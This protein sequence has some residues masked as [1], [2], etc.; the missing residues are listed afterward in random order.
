MLPY[1]IPTV[2]RSSSLC[3]SHYMM[4]SMFCNEFLYGDH[5]K[6]VDSGMQARR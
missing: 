2:E 1:A 4:T 5:R 3:H 6:K